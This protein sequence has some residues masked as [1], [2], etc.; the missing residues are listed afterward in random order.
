MDMKDPREQRA[1]MIAATCRITHRDGKWLV[2]SQSADKQYEVD[3]AS[4]KCT[5]PDCENGFLCKHVRA[6]KIVV[7]R[8][9]G[10][11][12][13][14]T[15]TQE[16]TF[17][18]KKT[19]KQDWPKYNEAQMTEKTRFLQLLYDLCR[20]VP[21]FPQPK[22]GAGTPRSPTWFSLPRSRSILPCPPAGSPATSR[23]PMSGAFCRN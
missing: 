22:T 13:D 3:I 8:E 23:M 20:K 2:P 10:M 21:D 18:E 12:G 11:N 17:T 7:R 14:I 19:Y 5:C 4:E 1:I 9:R 6:V 15:E 16:I